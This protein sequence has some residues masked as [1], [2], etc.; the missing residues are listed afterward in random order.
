MAFIRK[1][2]WRVGDAHLILGRCLS[3]ALGHLLHYMQEQVAIPGR[4]L[5]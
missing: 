1:L 3:L 5:A 4:H 2:I